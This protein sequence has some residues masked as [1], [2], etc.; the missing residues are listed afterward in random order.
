M[1]ESVLA[2][3]SQDSVPE[4]GTRGGNRTGMLMDVYI[5]PLAVLTKR[6]I[7]HSETPSVKLH[8][9]S[10]IDTARNRRVHMQTPVDG[11]WVRGYM[12]HDLREVCS[13][14]WNQN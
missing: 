2:H 4:L 1:V 6:S 3:K 8:T 9:V 7:N 12:R 13:E 5:V 14:V 10:T 11:C